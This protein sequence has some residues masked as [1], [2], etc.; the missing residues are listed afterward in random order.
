MP[1][2]DNA[3]LGHPCWIDLSTGDLEV[4]RRFYGE[5]LGWES[6]VN[7]E[8]GGYTSFTF[9]DLMVAGAMTKDNA[10][11]PDAWS[12]YLAVD[13]IEAA[14]SKVDSNGG[15]AVMGP[16]E[17][18]DLGVMAFVSDPGGA[19]IGM[20]QP[21]AHSGFGILAEPQTPSWF[22][23]H[24]AK[25]DE[26]IA[27]YENVFG[28]TVASVGDTDEFRYST[29]EDGPAAAAGVMDGSAYLP[30]GASAWAVYFG[31]ANAD[32]SAALAA[33]LGATQQDGIDDTPYGRLATFTDPNGAWFKLIEPPAQS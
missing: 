17:V 13:D 15:T 10:D 26:C 6:T 24:T 1:T 20:W 33:K 22:E 23:L 16:Q 32:E 2:R 27:F 18:G 14:L 5:L 8:F 9:N 4:S 25:F 3:P 11:M 30:E 31:V 28:W 21:G 7:E 12:V 29:L 19:M